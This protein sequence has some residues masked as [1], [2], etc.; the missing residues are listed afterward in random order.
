MTGIEPRHGFQATDKET[1]GLLNPWT[2]IRHESGEFSQQV[3]TSGLVPLS[4]AYGSSVHYLILKELLQCK[5]IGKRI[6]NFELQ[7]LIGL[8]TSRKHTAAFNF[9]DYSTHYMLTL[10][11]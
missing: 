8:T 6:N 9:P 4:L 10:S 2:V 5:N 3:P 1:R 11:P 7:N